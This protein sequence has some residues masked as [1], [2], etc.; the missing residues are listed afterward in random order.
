MAEEKI[1][2]VIIV[3]GAAAGLTAAIYSCRKKMSTLLVTVDVG[4]QNL[5][6]EQEENYP[7]YLDLSGPKLMQIFQEQAVKFGA[8]FVFGKAV[9]LDKVGE[10][11]RLTLGS[12]E[13]YIGK[14]IILAFGKIA[15]KLGV[16]GEDKFL[17]RGVHT[18]ATCLTPGSEIVTNPSIKLIEET[19]EGSLVFTG[20][21]KFEKVVGKTERNYEGE[22]LDIKARYFREGKLN[23]T[24][25]H[26]VLVTKSYSGYGRRW[27]NF[28]WETPSWVPAGML[29]KDHVLI[30]PVLREF[31]DTKNIKLS[32]FLG[33][34]VD[35]K[36]MVRNKFE[37][38]TSVRIKDIQKIDSKFCRLAGYF[39][40]DGSITDR[41][42][43]LY[44]A[45]SE[46][47]YAKDAAAIIKE[48]FGLK[49]NLDD[50]SNPIRV[51]VYS[52][53]VG[54][55]FE[56]LF[57]KYSYAKKMHILFLKL[58]KKKQTELI[59]GIWR[60]DGSTGY[61]NFSIVSNSAQLVSQIKMILLRLGIIPSV[62]YIPLEKLE[63]RGGIIDG[64]KLIFRHG[65][66]EVKVGGQFLEK[67]SKINGVNHPLL[68]KRKKSHKFALHLG[69]FAL[70]PIEKIERKYYSGNVY[71]IAVEGNTY[72]TH[73]SIVHNCDAPFAK[74]KTVAVVGGG[75]SAVEAAELVSKF[76]NKVYLI[77]RKE[78]FR[79]D[80][81]T[82]DKVKSAKNVELI[83]NSQIREIK[84]E[85]KVKGIVVENSKTNEK[86]EIALDS[87][88]IEI[89]YILDTE[90]VKHLVKTNEAG[91]IFVN[92]KGETSHPGLFAAGDVTDSPYKQTVTAAAE[93]AIAA[94][95]AYNYFRAKEGKPAIK[96][97]WD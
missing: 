28:D 63:G 21:G 15:R 13:N 41:G 49:V 38:H 91:E 36:G 39:L 20:R 50:K 54:M 4:G 45:S 92:K 59:K 70:L 68:D 72:V 88:F 44:F 19:E 82:V 77:H 3:G 95:T 60:G 89:G 79:A 57:G 81:I 51:E 96:V 55:L 18:C 29:S 84:G 33:L 34:Q 46:L 67:N 12:D 97:D 71:N 85:E 32:E 30:Y 65:K 24:P 35:K 76:A 7:G 80:P 78:E 27:S 43:N 17:G 93:G 42:F 8:E 1:Y 87:V 69:N 6:T 11:F 2:D 48:H 14:S 61:K 74:G 52:K 56:K 5:L 31:I 22:V 62:S 10:N 94:L 26:P 66:F 37:T 25:N 47:E 23:L 75:N 16:D 64:R 73:N 9:K 58:P 53:I 86:K 83:L 90:W 40:S